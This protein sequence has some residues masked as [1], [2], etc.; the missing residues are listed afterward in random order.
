MLTF[1]IKISKP[2]CKPLYHI[3]ILKP[4]GGTLS[5]KPTLSPAHRWWRKSFPP[6]LPA[7]IL[8]HRLHASPRNSTFSREGNRWAKTGITTW[9]IGRHIIIDNGPRPKS[10]LCEQTSRL[11]CA[12]G[13]SN[14]LWFWDCVFCFG[15]VPA[16]RLSIG[17]A[18]ALIDGCVILIG[19][20]PE[21]S[22]LAQN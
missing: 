11:R 22:C 2:I 18:T 17:Y 20:I 13:V 8:F 21:A 1:V 15:R 7:K 5:Q 19:Y 14:K 12:P 6:R 10:Y 16:S 3:T 9:V 4:K